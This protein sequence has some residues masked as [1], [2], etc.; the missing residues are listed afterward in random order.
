MKTIKSNIKSAFF[1]SAMLAMTASCSSYDTED[2]KADDNG[3]K[4]TAF[5][6]RNDVSATSRTSLA[7]HRLRTGGDFMWETGDEIFVRDDNGAYNKSQSSDITDTQPLAKFQV[8]G[9]YNSNNYEV[10]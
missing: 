1:L 6:S 7:N 9:T 2:T 5:A 3:K 10:Y 4:L 8:D